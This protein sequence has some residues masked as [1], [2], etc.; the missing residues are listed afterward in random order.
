MQPD[1]AYQVAEFQKNEGI[2]LMD[3]P[4]RFLGLNPVEHLGDALVRTIVISFL[5]PRTT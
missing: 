2:R 5:P 1:R 3:W 4:P